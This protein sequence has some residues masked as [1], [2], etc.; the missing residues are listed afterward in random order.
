VEFSGSLK[1]IEDHAGAAFVVGS[2]PLRGSK[3]IAYMVF[4]FVVIFVVVLV[5]PVVA[6]QATELPVVPVGLVLSLLSLGEAQLT[7]DQAPEGA[8]PR[9]SVAIVLATG[10]KVTPRSAVT[11]PVPKPLPSPTPIAHVI[12][13]SE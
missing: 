3:F 11:V 12:S 6:T 9:L 8:G 13:P 7:P 5:V 1:V 2:R 10:L 4:E